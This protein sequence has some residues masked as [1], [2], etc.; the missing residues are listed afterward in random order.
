ME[1]R[2]KN[3][4]IASEQYQNMITGLKAENEK[5]NITVEEMAKKLGLLK[6]E[7]TQARTEERA[8]I[9]AELDGLQYL[10]GTLGYIIEWHHIKKLLGKAITADQQ[11][12]KK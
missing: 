9:Y 7:L 11:G 12:E 2:L 5:L 3:E 8:R 1:N 6:T 4:M 10:Y